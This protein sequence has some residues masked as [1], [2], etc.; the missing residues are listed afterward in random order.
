[1]N[2][3]KADLN[4]GSVAEQMARVSAPMLVGLISVIAIGLSDAFFLA[5]AGEAELAAVGFVYPIIVAVSAFSVGLAAGANTALSQARGAQKD[6]DVVRRLALHAALL[7]LAFGLTF[8]LLFWLAAPLLFSLLGA[9]GAVL[10]NILAYLPFWIASFPILVVTMILDSAFR[11]AGDGLTVACVMVLTA[12]LNITFTPILIFGTGPAPEMGMAGA[13]LGTLA[14]RAI[15]FSLI[16]FLSIRRRMISIGFTSAHGLRGSV[17]QIVGTAL[18]AALSR[19]INP[20]GMAIVTAAVAVLGDTAVAGFGAAARVQAIAVVPFAALAAGVGPVV[21]QAWGAGNKLRAREAMRTA[22]VFSLCYGVV[23]GLTLFTFARPLAQFMTAGGSSTD[24]AASYLRFVGCSIG[25]YGFVLVAN[26]A[27]IGRS[28]AKWAMG[29]SLARIGI[30]Y[31][32]L[33]WLGMFTLGYPGILAAAILANLCGTWGALIA[34]RA[35]GIGPVDFT[36]V[37]QSANRL[38]TTWNR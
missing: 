20:A 1:M 5:R 25:T 19:A 28:Q 38:K 36:I 16:V 10:D 15:A 33:A 9:E 13:G 29:L 35:T 17:R 4:S 27:M 34:A 14:A 12:V 26:A 37:R 7:G 8:A 23:L 31:I 18:P 3:A 24:Y 11:A 32:P 21:G 6:D 22:A 2:S 30:I